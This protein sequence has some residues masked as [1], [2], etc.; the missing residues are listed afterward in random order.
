MLIQSKHVQNEIVRR[1]L[2][3]APDAVANAQALRDA[4]RRTGT[5]GESQ[6]NGF[7][8]A[9][10]EFMPYLRCDIDSFDSGRPYAP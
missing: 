4:V 10:G 1:A 3:G 6:L 9:D 5:P 8:N 2:A 7:Y